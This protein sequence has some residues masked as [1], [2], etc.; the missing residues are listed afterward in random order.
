MKNLIENLQVIHTAGI[1]RL[2]NRVTFFIGSP[3]DTSVSASATAFAF[4]SGERGLFA[5]RI[6][7]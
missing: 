1:F 7:Y 4:N 5:K 3:V 2:L 6:N